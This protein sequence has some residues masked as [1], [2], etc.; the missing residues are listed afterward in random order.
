M[1]TREI[2]LQGII[3][4][5]P[6]NNVPDGAMQE[7]INLRP[8]DGALRPVGMKSSIPSTPTDVR[9]I[10][11]INETTK[12]YIGT[13]DGKINYWIYVNGELSGSAVSTTID[14][15]ADMS[16]T[17]M[18]NALMISNHSAET[19]VILTFDHTTQQY[20]VFE[21]TSPVVPDVIFQKVA[22]ST[23]NSTS[24]SDPLVIEIVQDESI[25]IDQAES[26]VENYCQGILSGKRAKNYMV[27][28]YLIRCAWEL[29][30]GSII[31]QSIPQRI[32]TSLIEGQITWTRQLNPPTYTLTAHGRFTGYGVQY[33]LKMTSEELTQFKSQY[34]GLIRSLNFYCTR[35]KDIY[36]LENAT[37]DMEW[38]D[39]LD[40]EGP[41]MNLPK[42]EFA[43]Y[44]LYS[45]DLKD[46]TANNNTD[47]PAVDINNLTTKP[48]LPVNSLSFHS[49]YSRT[50]FSY[51]Q[52][53]FLGCVKNTLYKGPE[54]NNVIYPSGYQQN[55]YEI[56]FEWDLETNQGRKTVFGGWASCNTYIGEGLLYPQ[57]QV[58]NNETYIG[59][60]DARA[61]T[62]RLLAKQNDVVYKITEI[63]LKSVPELNFSY[64]T[65]FLVTC[66]KAISSYAEYTLQDGKDFYWD[67]NRVQASE[68]SNPFYWPAIN[69]YRVGN[70]EII[71]L[72]SNSI[73]LSAGQF[74]QFPVLCFTSE[75][76]WAMNVGNGEVLISNIVPLSPEVCNNPGSVTVTNRGIIFSTDK[77]LYIL[78]GAN[79]NEI[80]EPVEGKHTSW[81]SGALNYASIV[82][83]P[84]RYQIADYLCSVPFLTYLSGARIAYDYKREEILIS[85][86][87]Y[88]Y[89]WV[90]SLKFNTW[91]KISE[92]FERFVSVYPVVYGY[93]TEDSI[94]RQCNM[95]EE[96][97]LELRPIH[98]ETR[99]MKFGSRNFKKLH[100]MLLDG[101]INN[102]IDNPFSIYLFGSTD[103][104][105]WYLF[106]NGNTFTARTP[107]L[108]G[109]SAFSCLMYILVCGGKVDEETYFTTLDVEVEERWSQKIR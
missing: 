104:S 42:E 67:F 54:T 41:W 40:K 65:G 100:R 18:S 16:F 79:L 39:M 7:L 14:A 96:V 23:D 91:F 73:A 15:V 81:I 70:G 97:Y 34:K 80:S 53:I 31:M 57:F 51:N 68:L 37:L 32:M 4:N 58:W 95:S 11:V 56:G 89:S 76:I 48:I 55:P 59:Y 38:K 66:T 35:N 5:Q 64:Y 8:W 87:T 77:A 44:K 86:S 71:G 93:H 33:S 103:G 25:M 36:K 30:D 88:K 22:K 98:L 28:T 12:V 45:V 106:N 107:L 61:N 109:R 43:Y 63:E 105:K 69:S 2:K 9:Y 10:H 29:F 78:S 46:L 72:S 21:K 90:Y 49:L 24:S 60:P 85:N 108:I 20:K 1:A 3:R 52:R 27:G 62:L 82:D 26:F 50:L 99:P 47:L 75:G 83:N 84:N 13:A 19:I 94:Y 74:G 102:N 6:D 92:V 17:S 101:M